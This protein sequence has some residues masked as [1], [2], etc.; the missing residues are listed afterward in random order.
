ML[1]LPPP[2]RPLTIATRI[3]R[4]IIKQINA[5]S[6]VSQLEN[7]LGG[8]T[9]SDDGTEVCCLRRPYCILLLLL[10]SCYKQ[11]RF[12]AGESQKMTIFCAGNQEDYCM[13]YSSY[14]NVPYPRPILFM[15]RQKWHDA[16]AVSLSQPPGVKSAI[17]AFVLYINRGVPSLL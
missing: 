11:P 2:D 7:Y 15:I 14:K 6:T 4:R 17:E 10:S 12:A 5:G 8:I 9:M 13:V 16:L 1:L 3:L